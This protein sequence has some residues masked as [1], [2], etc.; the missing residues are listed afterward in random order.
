MACNLTEG[1]LLG[2]R[3]NAGGVQNMWIT[4]YSNITT[5]TQSTGD[6]ITA[7][8]GTGTFYAF[9]LI[10]TSSQFTET[11]NASLEAGTV[12]YQDELVTYFAKM[13]QTKRNI[14]KVLAQN[15]KLAIVFSDNNGEYWLMGQNY[16]SFISAGS[17]VSGKALGDANGLNMTFQ[18]L[19]QFPI[20]S[21]SGTLS[22]VCSGITVESI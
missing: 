13:D 14:L 15:Q 10:R 9:E 1:L 16:G 18:A 19:E 12:F 21:L 5:I 2:C 8:S 6:T 17:Q 11:V 7:I 4:D 3:D 20:N 22:S